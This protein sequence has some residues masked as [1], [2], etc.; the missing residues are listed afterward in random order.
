MMFW[1]KAAGLYDAFEMSYNGKTNR[2]LVKVV[3][4]KIEADDRVLECACGTGMISVGIAENC[5]KL[6]ATDFSVGMLRQARKKLKAYSNVK[7]AKADIMHLKAKDGSFDKVVAGN[8]IHLLDEPY[9]ALEELLRVCKSG[10][11]V[12]IPTYINKKSSGKESA[13]AKL[14]GLIGIDFKRQFDFDS[15]RAFFEKAGYDDVEYVVVDGRMPC[16]IASITKK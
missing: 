12:I 5:K 16:A 15:Y 6:V 10:G 13:A 9:A 7:L 3:S 4:E 1:D 11:Q 2:G 8:V 14:L